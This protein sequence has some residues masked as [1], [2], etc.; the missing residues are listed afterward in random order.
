[1]SKLA[2]LK[3]LFQTEGKQRNRLFAY[4]DY[5]DILKKGC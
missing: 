1:V 4:K 2:S 5:L 3:I